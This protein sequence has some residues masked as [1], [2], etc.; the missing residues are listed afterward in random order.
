MEKA[1]H[2]IAT[3]SGLAAVSIV[4]HMLKPGDHVVANDDLYGGTTN[5]LLEQGTQSEGVNVDF[6]DLRDLNAFKAG[7]KE[8]TKLVWA[9]TPTNPTLKV[10]DVL[11][12]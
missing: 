12:G 4:Y 11:Y 1:K 10:L 5:Y 2:C 9:E 3:S 8:N 6:I 7:I